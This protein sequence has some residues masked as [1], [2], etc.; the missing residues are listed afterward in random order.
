MARIL[1]ADDDSGVREFLEIMLTREGYAVSCAENG[2]EALALFRK[3]RSI[4]C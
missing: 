4:S 2:K 1:V 3:G